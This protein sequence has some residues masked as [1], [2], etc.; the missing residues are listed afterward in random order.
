MVGNFFKAVCPNTP[1]LMGE[2]TAAMI[3]MHSQINTWYSSM[4]RG[5]L[6]INNTHTYTYTY[7]Y[8]QTDR[9]TD[10]QTLITFRM[11]EKI[12]M[13]KCLCKAGQPVG[14]TLLVTVYSYISCVRNYITKWT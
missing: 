10:T 2:I 9:Q 11:S 6:I 5:L 7:T 1:S 12:T 13:L 4:V 14:L 3:I 8:T